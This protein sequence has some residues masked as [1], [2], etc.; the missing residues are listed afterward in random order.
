[1]K[2]FGLTKV[3]SVL[4]IATLM[5]VWLPVDAVGAN[6]ETNGFYWEEN[7][8]GTVT[9]TGAVNP[10]GDIVIPAALNGSVVTSIGKGA[11]SGCTGLL[12][13]TIPD[14]LVTI[15]DGAFSD[16][17]AL[18]EINLPNGL[19]SIGEYAFTSCTELTEIAFPDSIEVI[20]YWAFGNSGLKNIV[21]P[22]SIRNWAAW[23]GISAFL[24]TFNLESAVLEEGVPYIPPSLFQGCGKLHDVQIPS[25]VTGIGQYAFWQ[26]WDLRELTIPETVTWISPSAFESNYGVILSDFTL[27][28][29][30]GSYAEEYAIGRGLPYIYASPTTRIMLAVN[31]E[32]GTALADGFNINWYERGHPAVIATGS[33]VY[34]NLTEKEYDYEVILAEGLGCAYVQP[35]R[36][37]LD[38]SGDD[39]VAVTLQR[40]PTVT[41][42]GR[43]TDITG[44]PISGAAVRV[45]QYPNGQFTIMQTVYS[46]NDG[47]FTASIL[48]TETS[49]SISANGYIDK[50]LNRVIADD[51][52]NTVDLGAVALQQL[53]NK[54]ITIFMTEHGA[55]PLGETGQEY[56]IYSFDGL[57]FSL[58]NV[59]QNRA[60][61]LAAIQYP[62][63][64]LDGEMNPGDEIEISVIDSNGLMSA[65][66]VRISLD[67]ELNGTADI[68]FVDNGHFTAMARDGLAMVF[69]ATGI[70]VTSVFCSSMT[71]SEPLVEG[72]Y[73]V[74][75]MD[76][77]PLLMKVLHIEKLAEL[78]LEPEVDYT[79]VTVS[80][81]NGVITDLGDII[82]PI[83]DREKLF[84]TKTAQFSAAKQAVS[85]SAFASYRLSYE[86]DEKHM[87]SGE[88]LTVEFPAGLDLIADSV[89][90]DGRAAPY[91]YVNRV[92]TVVPGRPNA[93]LWFCATPS[94]PGKSFLTAYLSFRNED[95]PVIQPLGQSTVTVNELEI[96][97]PRSSPHTQV[98]VS[99]TAHANANI[100]IYD[101]GAVVGQ[102]VSNSIGEWH[103]SVE[104]YKPYAFSYHKIYAISKNLAGVTVKTEGKTL[105]HN[106]ADRS[107]P[108]VTMYNYNHVNN[109]YTII[110]YDNPT[111][112]RPI[113]FYWP[114]YDTFTFVAQFEDPDTVN[115]DVSIWAT[116]F[117]SVKR[118]VPLTYDANKKVWIGTA[119]FDINSSPQSVGVTYAGAPAEVLY[120]RQQFDDMK[121]DI[122]NALAGLEIDSDELRADLAAAG[123]DMSI[124][125]ETLVEQNNGLLGD[126]ITRMD[127][128]DG[129]EN[130]ALYYQLSVSAFSGTVSNLPGEGYDCVSGT[131]DS[132]MYVKNLET[133]SEILTYIVDTV[134]RTLTVSGVTVYN[135]V[136]PIAARRMSDIPIGSTIKTIIENLLTVVPRFGPIFSAISTV[137]SAIDVVEFQK[138]RNDVKTMI[139]N[140][141]CISDIVR[142]DCLQQLFGLWWKGT[143]IGGESIIIGGESTVIG[144]ICVIG[145]VPVTA[146]VIVISSL[147]VVSGIALG[148]AQSSLLSK[149]NA[150]KA[151]AIW[152]GLGLNGICCTSACCGPDDPDDE[153][154]TDRGLDPSGYV[155]EAVP[156]NRLEGV[157][158]TVYYKPMNAAPSDTGELWD[159]GDYWQENP[160]TTNAEG[161]YAWDVP[162]GLWQ[163]RFAKDGYEL[164]ESGW[165]PVPPPQLDVNIGMVSHAAPTV[166]NAKGYEDYI[167]IAFDK[168]MNIDTLTAED[169]ALTGYGGDFTVNFPDAEQ[170]P[171]NP[172]KI[173]VRIVRVIPSGGKFTM[174]GIIGLTVGT[175]AQSY[176][177]VR[178]ENTYQANVTIVPEPKGIN[179]LEAI[180]LNY[181][182]TRS[183]DVSIFPTQAGANKKI[184]AVSTSP[185]IATVSR[186]AVTDEN[187]VAA[188]SVSG[189]LSGVAEI[190]FKV[191]DT[192][193]TKT[194]TLS[195]GLPG[196]TVAE[197]YTVTFDPNGGVRTGG[198]ALTQMVLVGGAAVAP[199]VSRN[200]YTFNGWDTSF[201]SVTDDIAVTAR[202]AY[203]GG[204]RS[205]NPSTG[206][207][208]PNP[209]PSLAGDWE[210]PYVDVVDT[211]WFYE[212]VQF[213]SKRGLMIG[214]AAEKFS[215]GVTM[216]R[217]M[218][219]TAL[220]RLED[221]PEVSGDISFADVKTDGWYSRA[222]LWA[223]QN[224]IV[225]GYSNG[226]FGLDD[227]ITREQAVTIFYRYAE[228][229]GLDISVSA[230]LS[231]YT[232][233]NN[234]SDWALGAMKWAVAIGLIEGRA[235]TTTVPQGTSTRAELAMIFKGYIEDFLGEGGEED[236]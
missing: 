5:S 210:N 10:T 192:Q 88:T 95:G 127:Y 13:V 203:D 32:R 68:S 232:D 150:I 120:D 92:L 61:E 26:C 167:E 76:K 25:S 135:P 96:N 100:T 171:L 219:V 34:L 83:L 175:T 93:V 35:G 29:F 71:Q 73:S 30:P 56:G 168:Y 224:K 45:T 7:A 50:I 41:L 182:Q 75:F 200:G 189:E 117:D 114:G 9:V 78:G 106:A 235:D 159:A 207:T 59:T 206:K 82:I 111:G 193:L 152:D 133:D 38:L 229:K 201:D 177:G 51:A 54:K 1:M 186:S 112:K 91:T 215:P 176:A 230:D 3:L 148:L 113:Y 19:K 15:G 79:S 191:E 17:G 53:K 39:T 153:Q 128:N 80:I 197:S 146:S 223:N 81:A 142:T 48:N 98:N 22:G 86:L 36:V 226:K 130:A 204:D 11:F 188:F 23:E 214:T 134:K 162:W 8:D 185:F 234:I 132:E 196:E 233:M 149:L 213:I 85:M 121:I 118:N 208:V 126:Y 108:K 164:E 62:Y 90:L 145:A 119:D 166:A 187:G 218:L 40:I 87:V 24:G 65:L 129:T 216:S 28:V 102:A 47:F 156:S 37:P 137:G 163:V 209:K 69:G 160:L 20:A 99:G 211:D 184:I 94:L 101:S 221:E 161:Q 103:A 42:T 6:G 202:W 104:L 139:E 179:T 173:F 124:I 70:Y 122:E 115:G 72:D 217:A 151:R 143:L 178:L 205:P 131:D 227:P 220:Y 31:D 97:V 180:S 64:V 172:H 58:F 46:G 49:V 66:P 190:I 183:V 236:E 154:E 63:I 52:P 225:L 57:A 60:N 125:K 195:V 228:F 198:G 147:L 141:C 155:Y 43:V 14:S 109:G 231:K 74:V 33:S 77:T 84:Y 170:D 144:A 194:M 199:I 105:V 140:D 174:G 2:R 67:D 89:T 55:A 110:D 181:G 212:A 138:Q 4:L 44:D 18:T 16:C 123:I 21:I 222:I 157:T 136:M 169:I 107:R 12:S 116:G 165:L 158:A 27:R